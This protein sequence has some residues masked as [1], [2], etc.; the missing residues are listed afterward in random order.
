M[1]LETLRVEELPHYTYDDYAEWEGRWELIEGIPFAMSPM[2]SIEHQEISGLIFRHISDLLE[3]CSSCKAL[4]PV[5]WQITPDTIVQPDVLIVCDKE[6]SIKGK[7][8]SIPPVVVFEVL[9][10]STERKDRTT[11]YRLYEN[12]GVKYYCIVEPDNKCAEIFEFE[13]GDKRYKGRGESPG[14]KITFDL[15]ECTI[16]FDFGKIF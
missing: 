6:K 4:L 1:A 11:K 8:L 12:A 9:S 16:A 15:G 3:N 14:G 7:K 5:D 13:P 10:P 2:P